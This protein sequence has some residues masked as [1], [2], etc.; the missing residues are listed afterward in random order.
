MTLQCASCEWVQQMMF[1]KLC[2]KKQTLH[3]WKVCL[4]EVKPVPCL[5]EVKHAVCLCEVK[6]SAKLIIM[7][8]LS[9][10]LTCFKWSL[11]KGWSILTALQQIMKYVKTK[12]QQH[13]TGPVWAYTCIIKS[14]CFIML[15]LKWPSLEKT[16]IWKPG[17]FLTDKN[18]HV[19]S[20][21]KWWAFLD[22]FIGTCRN[23]DTSN[24]KRT[25]ECNQCL[26][27][28]FCWVPTVKATLDCLDIDMLTD[29]HTTWH[30]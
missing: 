29:E 28:C 3:V 17:N 6:H 4:R 18:L 26:S 21:H 20:N 7:P 9:W 30:C 19:N 15:Q 8:H 25:R 5:W 24:A 11:S 14:S 13:P 16:S 1:N 27:S 10:H 12:K 22:Q 23:G 2:G